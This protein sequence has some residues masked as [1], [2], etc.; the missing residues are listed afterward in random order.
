LQVLEA[1]LAQRPGSTVRIVEIGAG[2]GGTTGCVL[3]KLA[4]RRD[5]FEY[6]YTDLSPGFVQHGR[7]VF[8]ERGYRM[9]FRRLDI[10]QPPATG[11]PS[12][13]QAHI[14]IATNVLHATRRIDRTL[15]TCAPWRRTTA[16]CCST[17]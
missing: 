12:L 6:V 15:D 4:E 2:T 16:C 8:G 1:R 9:E 11:S 14:V 10:E 7:Q 13:G 17:N 3:G 5:A